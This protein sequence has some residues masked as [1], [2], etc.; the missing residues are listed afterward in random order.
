MLKKLI[1]AVMLVFM[2]ACANVPTSSGCCGGMSMPCKCCEKCESCK[3][4]NCCA[5]CKGGAGKMCQKAEKP[6]PGAK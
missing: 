6:Q 4:N 5:S 3:D 2:S 1:P